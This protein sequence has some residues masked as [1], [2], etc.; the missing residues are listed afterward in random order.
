MMLN[1]TQF[2]FNVGVYV[3]DVD[4]IYEQCKPFFAE[5]EC[6]L[7]RLVHEDKPDEGPME[8]QWAR[9]ISLYAFERAVPHLDLV[10]TPTGFG[11]VSNNT[12]SPASRERVQ[13]LRDNLRKSCA[14]TAC[15]ILERLWSDI[16]RVRKVRPVSSLEL[17]S[18]WK[19]F[20]C[21]GALAYFDDVSMRRQAMCYVARR[22]GQAQVDELVAVAAVGD[23][24]GTE[25]HK[26]IAACQLQRYEGFYITGNDQQ[27]Y[28]M[29]QLVRY[30]D[31]CLPYFPLYRDS[32]ERKARKITYEN[33][34]DSPLYFF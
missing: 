29:E 14:E 33:S 31:G 27:F 20:T 9:Y 17:P 26:W 5:G 11:I 25:V 8:H 2:V 18:K 6:E 15:W 19:E 12:L 24:L 21:R 16:G 23:R 32:D 13:S 1:K 7:R 28:Q 30:L 22:I 3:S 4:P 34:S 10:L